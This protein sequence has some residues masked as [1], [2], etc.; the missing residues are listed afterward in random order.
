MM[1]HIDY[2][3]PILIL[4]LSGI[5]GLALVQRLKLSPI[6]GY[7][8]A[9]ILIGPYGLGLVGE[10]ATI[11]TIAEVGVAFLLF[12]IGISLSFRTLW[13]SRRELFG[14]GPFQITVTSL[15]MGAIAYWALRD[16]VA[17]LVIGTG[18]SLSSTAITMQVLK[19][20]NE[21]ETPLGRAAL[22]VLLA[23]DIF[24][25]FLLILVPNL[26][27]ATFNLPTILGVAVLKILVALTAVAI[28]GRFL[29]RPL[30]EWITATK[31]DEIFTASALLFVLAS[32][33]GISQLGL[34][35][36]LGAFLAGLAL[37]E[38]DF[39]YLVKAEIQ[40]FRGL[41]L[42]LF[43]ITVG[44]SLNWPLAFQAAGTLFILIAGIISLKTISSWAAAQ[45]MRFCNGFSI[46]LGLLL[47]QGSEF[48]F[49]LFSLAAAENLLSLKLSTLLQVAVSCT[50]ALT[51]LLSWLGRTIGNWIEH[52]R[53][54]NEGEG[55]TARATE[56]VII[57]G[58]DNIGQEIAKALEAE[59]ISYIAYDNDRQR[60][61]QSRGKGFQVDYSDINR[62]KT[63]SAA[64]VG[65]AKAVIVLTDDT[66]TVLYLLDALKQM[67][68]N[69]PVYVATTNLVD[70]EKLS[71]IGAAEVFIKNNETASLIAADLMRKFS[72][73]EEQI[74]DRIARMKREQEASLSAAN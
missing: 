28:V 23:Q 29:L 66:E 41:L 52:E 58:F 62:P 57:S 39:C 19:G 12:N 40:P 30:F 45:L 31:S 16:L 48:A 49:V 53:I 4:L 26:A 13:E 7:F 44:M 3:Q 55:Q 60:I 56:K 35:L 14:L 11:R 69:F 10:S 63:A 47:A 71:T 18:L 73:K 17:A 24:V 5:L 33:W 67:N 59:G 72:F 20:S 21:Q 64:S 34:S 54:E 32:A 8:L 68:P 51:P 22:A 25:I 50:L 38:S 43:F 2:L 42:G 9:G 1:E 70:F 46:R 15:L 36:P 74:A 61:A 65:K 37:S 27:S 6:L